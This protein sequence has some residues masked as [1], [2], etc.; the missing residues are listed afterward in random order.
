MKTFDE[1]EGMWQQ[2]EKKALPDASE[3]VKKTKKMRRKIIVKHTI[4]ISILV[5]TFI[6]ISTFLFTYQFAY[7][8]TYIGIIVVLLTVVM[9]IAFRSQLIGI[10]L[11]KSDILSDSKHH[12]DQNLIYQSR[13]KFFHK[14]GSSLYYLSLSAG[15]V[16]YLYEFAS[17]DFWF[18][19]AA[20]AITGVWIVFSWFY[21]RKRNIEKH[22]RKIDEYIEEL[23]RTYGGLRETE[24]S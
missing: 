13:L 7:T 24:G 16:L 20:Y 15:L 11:P 22:E 12:L 5:L 10:M 23:R 2:Q 3:I 6:Y 17:R 1:I 21:L 9:G 19:I 14:A 4:G 18:G 8:T